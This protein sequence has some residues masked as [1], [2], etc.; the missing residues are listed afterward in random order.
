MSDATLVFASATFFCA[1]ASILVNVSICA[2]ASSRG[3]PLCSRSIV[4]ERR[5]CCGHPV[6]ESGPALALHLPEGEIGD[7]KRNDRQQQEG[8]RCCPDAPAFATA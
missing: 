7:P 8:L 2:A 5:F 6:F 1:S 4:F 3:R